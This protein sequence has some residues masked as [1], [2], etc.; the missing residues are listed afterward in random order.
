MYKPTE[1]ID[2]IKQ[3][4]ILPLF[5]HQ[6]AVVSLDVVRTLYKAGIRIMEYT[7]RGET[8]FANFKHIKSAAKDEMPD[9]I[10]SIGTIKSPGEAEKFIE[11]EADFIIAPIINPDVAKV[12]HDADLLWVPG[13]MTPTE[14]YAAQINGAQL[15]KIFPG[16]VVGPGFI[17]AIKELFPGMYFMPT[18]GVELSVESINKWRNAGAVAVGLGSKLVT[19]QTLTDK[20]YDQLYIETKRAMSLILS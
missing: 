14:I 7:N 4:G 6:D 13:C 11:A 16:N 17:S 3:Q 12:V 1:I 18:G 19:K 2:R 10:L 20:N 9:L 5:F 15:V 8:A